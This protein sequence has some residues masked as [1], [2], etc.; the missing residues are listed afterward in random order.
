MRC[1]VIPP[2]LTAGAAGLALAMATALG[3][4]HAFASS[5]AAS[6]PAA[7]P[8]TIKCVQIKKEPNKE[9]TGQLCSNFPSDGYSGPATVEET[10]GARESFQCEKVT[11]TKEDNPGKGS[12]IRIKGTG[13]SPPP[14]R[15]IHCAVLNG[16]GNGPVKRVFGDSCVG[17]LDQPAGPA[18]VVSSSEPGKAF[19][20]A[21]VD[22]YNMP[23]PDWAFPY[24]INGSGCRLTAP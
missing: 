5:E 11:L 1:Q 21:R 13:C 15:T 18:K 3:P 7:A 22:L 23:R 4:S 20:C 17:V 16:V 24:E 12:S 2:L 6:A 10:T 19:D 8:P 14:V 9:I